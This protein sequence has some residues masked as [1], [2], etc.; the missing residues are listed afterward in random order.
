MNTKADYVRSQGQTR[1]HTCH[2][3]GCE[4]QVPP[5]MLGCKAHWFRLPKPLRDQIWKEYRPGQ[6]ASGTPSKRYLIAAA[7]VQGWIAGKVTI[8]ADGS[9]EVHEDLKV[10]Q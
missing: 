5:A 2:W 8:N 1:S 9:I 7:L 4:K 3:P 6:E 10:S